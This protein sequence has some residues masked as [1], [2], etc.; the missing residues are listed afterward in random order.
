MQCHQQY[1]ESCLFPELQV[2]TNPSLPPHE[3]LIDID[4][5]QMVLTVEWAIKILQ[6]L[7][8]FTK[9]SSTHRIQLT[10]AIKIFIVLSAVGETFQC[11][12]RLE[13][14]PI[15]LRRLL[16]WAYKLPKQELSKTVVNA[17]A[18]EK[19]TELLLHIQTTNY[20]RHRPELSKVRFR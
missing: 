8:L 7:L 18:H 20:S 3:I 4:W 15:F 14:V 9:Y 2:V 11:P 6:L 19:V 13:L 1:N 10:I 16:L 12:T 17:F 5:T